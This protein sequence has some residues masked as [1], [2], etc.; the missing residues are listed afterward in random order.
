MQAPANCNLV[1]VM[2]GG[3]LPTSSDWLERLAESALRGDTGVVAPT[4][5]YPN[6]S[7]R[8]A[9]L[10]FGEGDFCA[11]VSRFAHMDANVAADGRSVDLD[12]LRG[13]REVSAVSHHC[14]MFRRSVFLDQGQFALDFDHQTS[15]VDFCCRLRRAGLSV[16]L[17]GRIVMLQDDAQPR[18]A[19]TLSEGQLNAFKAKHGGQLW[20][21]DPFGPP[22][23]RTQIRS[24]FLPPLECR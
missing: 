20:S 24:V 3:V 7:I 8:H 2:D 21:E 10:A 1:V 19:R 11:Y 14:M 15:D 23:Q 6:G 22:S 17:D 18:W 9:G 16:L 5:L 12:R 4:T 13:L